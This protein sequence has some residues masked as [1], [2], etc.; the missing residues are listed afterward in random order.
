MNHKETQQIFLNFAKWGK[1][2][3]QN[4][5]STL[6]DVN[7]FTVMEMENKYSQYMFKHPD[8]FICKEN[9]L[10]NENLNE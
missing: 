8:S 2:K 10:I 6:G 4:L 7:Y 9:E 5:K 3:K 1:K